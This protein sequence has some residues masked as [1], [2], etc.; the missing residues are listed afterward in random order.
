[1]NLTELVD[2]VYVMTSR[3]DLTAQSEQAV[4]L[5]TLKLHGRDYYYK[6][7]V[8]ATLLL[9]SAEYIQSFDYKTV[10]T[11][12]QEATKFFEIIP[13]EFVT[14]GY[15]VNREDV[16]YMA[17]SLL[18]IRS[19][20]P[21]N[22]YLIGYYQHPDITTANWDSWIANEIPYAIVTEAARRIFKII[23]KDD[24]YARLEN[25]MRE[26]YAQIDVVG[27]ANTGGY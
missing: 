13:T 1:V 24:E 11:T 6:D 19:S 4:K 9:P 16:C 20:T 18:N 12:A 2:E 15:S 3:S 8:G 17:G 7:L 22:F 5:A 25:D 21:E 10:D 27:L 26:Y 14:D 23:G